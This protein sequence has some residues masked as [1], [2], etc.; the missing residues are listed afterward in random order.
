MLITLGTPFL[1]QVS[2]IGGWSDEVT[3]DL[4]PQAKAAAPGG[5]QGEPARTHEAKR[6]DLESAA[7]WWTQRARI[8]NSRRLIQA[9]LNAL[10]KGFTTWKGPTVSSVSLKRTPSSRVST[11]PCKP[12]RRWGVVKTVH[13]I[14]E[15][16]HQIGNTVGVIQSHFPDQDPGAQRRPQSARTSEQGPGARGGDG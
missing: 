7:E 6:D 10:G 3:G 15:S 9:G 12:R 8:D 11:W 1:G 5:Q 13:G 14:N 4:V 16:R 2:Q